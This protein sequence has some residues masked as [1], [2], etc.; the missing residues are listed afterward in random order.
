MA[1]VARRQ[2]ATYV[3]CLLFGS[4]AQRITCKNKKKK[5]I[6]Y[7]KYEHRSWAQTPN[8]LAVTMQSQQQRQSKH[9]PNWQKRQ[10][11]EWAKKKKT[12]IKWKWCVR[13]GVLVEIPQTHGPASVSLS[14]CVR[15]GRSFSL[16]L[17]INS[18]RLHFFFR[19]ECGNVRGLNAQIIIIV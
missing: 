4:L 15:V 14:V 2:Q 5:Q 11:N 19:I 10:G 7:A 8:V 13:D 6:V 9:I 18:F 3:G 16:F 1:V 12:H 17:F